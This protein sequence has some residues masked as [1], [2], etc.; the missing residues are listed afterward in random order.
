[1]EIN[2]RQRQPVTIARKGDEKFRENKEGYTTR[3]ILM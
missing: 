2:I 1:M 3:I